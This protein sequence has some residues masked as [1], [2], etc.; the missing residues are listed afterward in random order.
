MSQANPTP[1]DTQTRGV[2]NPKVVDLIYSE[3]VD[4]LVILQM[5]EERPW[6]SAPEQLDQLGEKFNNYLDYVLDGWFFK[7][8]P[9]HE[10]KSV[11]LELCYIHEPPQET[12]VRLSDLQR[13]CQSVGLSFRF[14]QREDIAAPSA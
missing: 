1:E 6:N 3:D 8:Y 7:Q 4:N 10:G 13:F 11:C 12:A 9:M 2:K 14:S 5:F